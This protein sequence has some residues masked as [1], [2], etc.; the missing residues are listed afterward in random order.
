M[1]IFTTKN[2]ASILGLNK[3]MATNHYIICIWYINKNVMAY[4]I[5]FFKE[6]D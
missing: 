5:K 2:N 4:A 1:I 3:V 6:T